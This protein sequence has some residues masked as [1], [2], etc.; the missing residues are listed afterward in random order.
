MDCST[1]R[2]QYTQYT[3]I[4]IAFPFV[5]LFLKSFLV[6]ILKYLVNIRRFS[7]EIDKISW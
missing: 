5:I 3:L 4:T 6:S 1:F 2:S 7:Y